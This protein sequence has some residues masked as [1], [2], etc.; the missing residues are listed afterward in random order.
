MEGILETV[1]RRTQMAGENRLE[2]LLFKLDGEQTYGINVFKVKEII[3]SLTLTQ[4]PQSSSIVRGISHVRGITVP[5]LDIN[6]AIGGKPTPKPENKSVILAEYN[7][8]IQGFLVFSVERIVDS[9]WEDILAPPAGLGNSTYLTAVTRIKD[10]L[11]EIIDVEKILS[12]VAPLKEY[13]IGIVCDTDSEHSKKKILVC[14][15][16]VV[17]RKQVTNA[18]SKVGFESVVFKNGLETLH[19]LKSLLDEGRKPS[20]EYLMLISDVEMPEMDGYK[21]S[22]EIKT[23]EGMKDLYVILHTSLSGVFNNSL[24]KK[25][26]ADKFI[27]KFD[28][29][30][31]AD[32]VRSRLEA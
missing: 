9:T 27:A 29:N 14:D 4:I 24:V 26:G 11:V 10:K 13:D 30:A 5:V 6:L 21:L 16:S 25:V 18:L 31:L 3:T 28:P 23:N 22:T 17:A 1:N 32:S 2:L 15:D 20:D 19:H 7:Q 12:D 8:G